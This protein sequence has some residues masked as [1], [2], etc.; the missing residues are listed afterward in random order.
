MGAV[1]RLSRSLRLAQHPLGVLRVALGWV[2]ADT[3]NSMMNEG[4]TRVSYRF[5]IGAIY[6]L[7][8]ASEYILGIVWGGMLAKMSMGP[9][10]P[11]W[12]RVLSELAQVMAQVPVKCQTSLN[13]GPMNP[14]SKRHWICFQTSLKPV[15]GFRV[16]TSLARPGFKLSGG[17]YR[18]GFKLSGGL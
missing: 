6:V 3:A 15:S 9:P 5:F 4:G 13:P 10:G 2:S 14:R 1:R 12:Q 8:G 18:P 16:Q 17:L 11:L 7:F